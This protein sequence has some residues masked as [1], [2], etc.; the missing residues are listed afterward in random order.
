MPIATRTFRFDEIRKDEDI[1]TFRR[2][3]S[4]VIRPVTPAGQPIEVDV[5]FQM[6]ARYQTTNHAATPRSS[7][8]DFEKEVKRALSSGKPLTVS[9][10]VRTFPN[11][12]RKVVSAGS[13]LRSHGPIVVSSPTA[14]S[15]TKVD[16]PDEAQ[17]GSH[18]HEIQRLIKYLHEENRRLQSEL[19]ATKRTAQRPELTREHLKGQAFAVHRT[20]AAFASAYENLIGLDASVYQHSGALSMPSLTESTRK[21]A[22]EPKHPDVYCDGPCDAAVH[23]IRWKCVACEDFDYCEDCYHEQRRRHLRLHGAGHLFFA[24]HEPLGDIHSLLSVHLGVKPCL[25]KPSTEQ[26]AEEVKRPSDTVC[27]EVNPTQITPQSKKRP[28]APQHWSHACDVQQISGN[29][30]GS[31]RDRISTWLSSSPRL[32]P[33]ADSGTQRLVDLDN[34]VSKN[35]VQETMWPGSTSLREPK[36][37]RKQHT[38]TN[39]DATIACEL[40]SSKCDN[41]KVPATSTAEAAKVPSPATV[42]HPKHDASPS[43]DEWVTKQVPAEVFVNVSFAAEQTREEYDATVLEEMRDTSAARHAVWVTNSGSA[44]WDLS[45]LRV[46]TIYRGVGWENDL[47]DYRLVGGGG[48]FVEP[49]QILRV[50]LVR[51][52]QDEVFCRLAVS[53]RST[54]PSRFGQQLHFM[55]ATAA[56]HSTASIQAEIRADNTVH[57][58]RHSEVAPTAPTFNTS[59]CASLTGSSF[60]T[61]PAAPESDARLGSS[62]AALSICNSLSCEHFPTVESARSSTRDS[63]WSSLADAVKSISARSYSVSPTGDRWSSAASSTDGDASSALYSPAFTN[64]SAAEDVPAWTRPEDEDDFTLLGFQHHAAIRSPSNRS[65]TTDDDWERCSYSGC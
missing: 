7:K 15:Q 4:E 52:P 9:Y 45:K 32:A 19:A 26:A 54:Y 24:I 8:Q 55:P 49:T 21:A 25:C 27:P 65:E 64:V 39:P 29:A 61:I 60:L 18:D 42:P 20:L 41:I 2:K 46:E 44:T 59:G 17:K 12:D 47:P 63:M 53:D 58:N 22:R 10:R 37:V 33:T 62:Q 3:L 43:I 6:P 11:K 14:L 50:E 5:F 16:G 1:R 30:L 56:D 28:P 38:N 23:G 35:Q 13:L 57:K 48:V 36:D 34:K 40:L 31:Q 51:E